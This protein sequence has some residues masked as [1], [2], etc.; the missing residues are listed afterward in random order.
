MEDMESKI[1]AILNNPQMME[2]IMSLAQNLGS[3]QAAAPPPVQEGFPEIDFATVQKLT[4]LIGKT[5][6]DGQQRTLLQ[7]L[8]PYL[9]SQRIHK[10]EK[11]MRAAK[12]AGM[13]S[14]FFANSGR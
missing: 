2:Q 12:L 4:S 10:L 11:A 1:G 5:G 14:V 6:I 3:E 9:S 8:G 7:A 13:A